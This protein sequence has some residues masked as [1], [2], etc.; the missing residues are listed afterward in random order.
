VLVLTDIDESRVLDAVPGHDGAAAD[1]LWK[2]SSNDQTGTIEA[3][4]KIRGQ[5]N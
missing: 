4:G 3:G 2:T 1:S 5:E